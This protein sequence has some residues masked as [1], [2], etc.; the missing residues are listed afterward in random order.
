MTR[1]ELIY[2]YPLYS[3]SR[4][5]TFVKYCK[6]ASNAIVMG[7]GKFRLPI[8]LDMIWC[9]LRYGAMDSR[10]YLLFEF[11]KKSALERNTFF[12]KRRYFQLIKHFD[13][14]LFIKLSDKDYM[15]NEYKDFIK[16]DWLIVN[17]ECSLDSVK[18]FV[19]KH[20]NV[21][22]KP[23]SSEQGSGIIKVNAIEKEKLNDL[24]NNRL[25]KPFLLEEILAN[26]DE[27]NK[28]NPSSLNT[29]RVYTIVPKNGG[30][31]IAINASLRCGRG[32]I[33]VDNWGSGGIGYPIDL[34]NGIV[35]TYGRNKKG[36]PFA[37]HPD[38][39]IQMIG[40]K[41][42]YFQ[43]AIQFAIDC[44]KHNS[45]VLYA[46]IDVALTPN[47]PELVELNFP[48]GHD[49]LQALDQVGKNALMQTIIR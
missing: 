25:N 48:G 22:V 40:F 41:I 37:Y 45:K 1:G 36:Q 26:C 9:N 33:V 29:L 16:R 46:G 39:N 3:L 14:E 23:I 28:I 49:F 30:N 12:T 13:K 31:P 19:N 43:E 5:C 20:K 38:S 42:P 4:L 21:I 7:G 47:G 35:F 32:N 17:S 11:W 44:A 10:D 24:F 2:N 15:Y 34:N 27:L 18:E 8:I 6:S